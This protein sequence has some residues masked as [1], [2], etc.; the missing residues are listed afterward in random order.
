MKVTVRTNSRTPSVQVNVSAYD[1]LTPR[2]AIAAAD[3]AYGTYSHC[4][5]YN[6]DRQY[7][8]TGGAHSKRRAVRV[9]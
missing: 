7:R 9:R 1:K 2:S 3:I 4:D 6:N 5:V 8:V